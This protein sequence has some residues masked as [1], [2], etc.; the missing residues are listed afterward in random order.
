MLA[1]IRERPNLDGFIS[2]VLR[3]R[4]GEGHPI[5]IVRFSTLD[6]G[7]CVKSLAAR[8]HKAV[9]SLHHTIKRRLK[10]AALVQGHCRADI[11]QRGDTEAGDE[12]WGCMA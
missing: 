1:C 12:R 3:S 2:V 9:C 8:Y 11:C 10:L 5:G 4:S 6:L 7:D